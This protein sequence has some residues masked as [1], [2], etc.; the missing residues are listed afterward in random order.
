MAFELEVD[1]EKVLQGESWAFD[2]HLVVLQKYD[3]STSIQDLNFTTTK[4]WV[5][6]HN[7][8]YSLLTT[9]TALSIGKTLGT[10]TK[11]KDAAEMR[12]GNFMHVRVAVDITKSLCRGR[13][14]SWDQTEKGWV[15]F[16]YERLLNICYWCGLLSHNDKDC[17]LWLNSK[18]TLT[19]D[20]QQFGSWIRA[21]QFNPV[22]RAVVE[23]QGFEC[24][25][26]AGTTTKKNTETW[27][28][29]SEGVNQGIGVIT[30]VDLDGSR[31]STHMETEAQEDGDDGGMDHAGSG[32]SF[33]QLQ[34]SDALIGGINDNNN[35]ETITWDQTDTQLRQPPE[36]ERFDLEFNAPTIKPNNKEVSVRF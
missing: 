32:G 27:Q 24:N 14:V 9:E 29:R 2:R 17:V 26:T 18:G 25:T 1:A 12:G 31:V 28:G 4:F 36:M 22:R 21:Q 11:P 23:V 15:S 13:K 34:N 6:F 33:S 10:I 30:T 3:G 35:A 8:P 7:L 19:A 5:Q 16:R 20:D